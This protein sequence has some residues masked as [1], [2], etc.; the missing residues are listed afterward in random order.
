M[1]LGGCCQ[2]PSSDYLLG[3]CNGN[4]RAVRRLLLQRADWGI[5]PRCE[6]SRWQYA[7]AYLRAI[8]RKCCRSYPSSHTYLPKLSPPVRHRRNN[9]KRP[10]RPLR[11]NK[12][13]FVPL[14]NLYFLLQSYKLFLILSNAFIVIFGKVNLVFSNILYLWRLRTRYNHPINND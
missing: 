12:F 5:S 10:Q 6:Q 11:M 14:L 3:R 2:Y 4:G 13:L 8:S 7:S 1:Q 9:L